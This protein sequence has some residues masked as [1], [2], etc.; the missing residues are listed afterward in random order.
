MKALITG[1]TSG[2]GYGVAKQLAERGWDVTI[3]GRSVE[4][5]MQIASEIGCHFIQADLSLMSE[6][7]RLAQQIASPLDALV[8]CA[9]G[10]SMGSD[11]ILTDEGYER[12]FATNYLGR[13]VLSQLLLPKMQSG[14]V[15][16]MVSGN[17]K[18]KNVSTDWENHDTGMKSAFKAALAVD[19]YAEELASSVNNLRV[20]TC[21]PGWV[22]TNLMRDAVL[23]IRLMMRLLGTPIEK[24][25]AYITRLILEDY[26]GVHW[27]KDQ[28]MVFPVPLPINAEADSL[29]RY[30]QQAMP[31]NAIELETR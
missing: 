26:D 7:H 18:H 12:T 11:V 24:G 28:P 27:M 10:V 21:Y 25:S 29:W 3:V 2:L 15:V 16:M 17:G 9:G 20:H 23:P 6:V 8:M 5:G 31:S 22:R 4:N 13:F 1:G 19:M 14:G 30:S